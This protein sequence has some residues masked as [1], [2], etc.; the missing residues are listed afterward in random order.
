VSPGRGVDPASIT[1]PIK[2]KRLVRKRNVATPRMVEPYQIK[3]VTGDARMPYMD[4]VE[5]MIRRSYAN[6]P[7][8]I[9][10]GFKDD[11]L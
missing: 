9:R 1:D 10:P 5:T 7:K 11:L 4:D 2:L 8:G 6:T 3:K